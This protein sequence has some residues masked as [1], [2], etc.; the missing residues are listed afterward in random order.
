MA[1]TDPDST[2]TE[3]G[4]PR[5]VPEA[6][7]TRLDAGSG[8]VTLDHGGLAATEPDAGHE[9]G[10]SA[11]GSLLAGRYLLGARLGEGG[12]GTV[13]RAEQIHPVKRIVA[14]KLVKAGMDSTRVIARFEAERQAVALMDHPNI[15]RVFD[16]GT[17]PDGRPFFVMELVDGV[18]LTDYCDARRL[19]VR[20]RLELF[21]A[22]CQAVQHAHQKG[23]IHRDLKPSNIL[24]TEVDGRPVPKVIDFGLAKALQ[25]G[26]LPD[27]SIDTAFGSV[28][29]TPLY[30]AP[31]QAV[32]GSADVD[33][34]ADLYALGVVLY[35]LLTGSTPLSRETLK[36]AAL[37]EV[38]RLVQQADTPTPT[39][40]LRAA[41]DGPSV[42]A[43]RNT[44]PA[45]LAR[46]V[47]GDL[48]WIVLKCLEKDRSRRYETANGL[49]ADVLRHL[50]DEPVTA[51]PPGRWYRARKFVR[52]NRGPV[53]AGSLV[54]LALVAGVVGT[55]W[56]M[57]RARAAE[58]LAD[59][60]LLQVERA[61][62]ETEKALGQSEAARVKAEVAEKQASA[63]ADFLVDA[64]E[65]PN[66]GEDGRQVKVVDLLDK[67]AAKLEADG[68]L[69][70]LARARLQDALG[71]T[72]F[73]LGLMEPALVQL[74]KSRTAYER[75]LGLDHPT[76]LKVM[77]HLSYTLGHAGRNDEAIKLG[78]QTLWRRKAVLGPE[79][80]DTLLTMGQLAGRYWAA[81][82]LGDA[83]PL[84]EQAVAGQRKIPDLKADT[85]ANSI[86]NL[87]MLYRAAGRTSDAVRLFEEGVAL[88][89]AKHGPDH[90]DTVLATSFLAQGY[91]DAGRTDDA[92]ALQR[93]TL[94]RM[95]ETFG[96]AHPRTI[97]AMKSLAF[98]YRS[99][100][101][102]ADALSINEEVL[103]L[104]K[105][106]AHPDLA[107]VLAAERDLSDAY[108][109][110]DRKAEAMALL[111]DSLARAR[112][113][114]GPK[115][116]ETRTILHDLGVRLR[117]ADRSAEAIP[118]LEE[119]AAIGKELLRQD[120]PARQITLTQ[121][122]SAYEQAG[123]PGDAIAILEPLLEAQKARLDPDHRDLLV[124]E[125]NLAL[126]YG[127]AGRTADAVRLLER[128]VA[129]FRKKYGPNYPDLRTATGYL[130]AA[131]LKDGRLDVAEAT[132]RDLLAASRPR[133]PPDSQVL[134]G[135][136][137]GLGDTLLAA[138]KFVEA[139]AVLRESLAIRQ[140]PTPEDWRA[141]GAK[142]RLG[143][144]LAGQG[145]DEAAEPLLRAGC[146]GLKV[147][148]RGEPSKARVPLTEAVDRLVE[149]YK[150][151]GK[152]E[153]A[154][155][156]RGERPKSP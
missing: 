54:L 87:A 37:G 108:N 28:L 123:R 14:V 23:V 43:A 119:A 113:H 16:A 79:H 122:A 88:H 148:A 104:Q 70:P 53:L 11:A 153:E 124:T 97:E 42:A 109:L 75:G 143:A 63:V 140:K 10:P 78:E 15:A 127:S 91:R 94:A 136:L 36:R 45:R 22:V 6:D 77:Y 116:F 95:K 72:F 139:E 4:D 26:S 147:I 38:L 40:R 111:R 101:K 32:Y 99:T 34:R 82:R 57:V 17:N 81:S 141:S 2:R 1:S 50:A 115:H 114:F 112:A 55:T 18:P 126:A 84:A 96:P 100:G 144:A 128:I 151:R 47:R 58:R 7:A 64:F 13:F 92:I 152:T 48:E 137:S 80:E 120:D 49:A 103:R 3:G 146:E 135:F 142:S 121:L 125:S 129:A 66:P 107:D 156:W 33:T 93:D 9:P 68:S 35:E 44:E 20:A 154:D 12:M 138:R 86:I 60:R 98:T 67:A 106:A 76:T 41:T 69:D 102:S 21:I 65:R 39:A 74:E 118:L 19:T 27:L 90:A 25:A 105:S 8:Q 134:A 130:A 145:K 24:V 85:L 73:G 117:Q 51:G 83:V 29:G 52:R 149:F 30:M 131:Y 150:A 132:Y 31:E 110:L 89:K 155:R 5:V 46:E 59:N 71:R 56:G 61:R 62:G 133:L